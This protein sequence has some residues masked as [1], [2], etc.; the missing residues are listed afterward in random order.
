MNRRKFL[1]GASTLVLASSAAAR[2]VFNALPDRTVIFLVK[3]LEDRTGFMP[4]GSVMLWAGRKVPPGHLP[5]DGRSL[6]ASLYPALFAAIGTGPAPR[7]WWHFGRR[8]FKLPDMR[9]R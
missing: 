3:V 9:L 4:V 5:A 2:V 1:I 8:R 6:D 7:R